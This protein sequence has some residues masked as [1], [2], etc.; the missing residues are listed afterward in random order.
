MSRERESPLTATQRYLIEVAKKRGKDAAS[1]RLQEM[2]RILYNLAEWIGEKE[3]DE[4]IET[5]AEIINRA[6]S[7]IA[8]ADDIA[9]DGM[10]ELGYEQEQQED[11]AH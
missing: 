4:D 11:T 3:P 6:I 10:V 8:R 5:N 7:A 1:T 2:V 9:C